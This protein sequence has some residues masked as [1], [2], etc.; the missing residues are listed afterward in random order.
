M[1]QVPEQSDSPAPDLANIDKATYDEMRRI[2][3]RLV[4]RGRNPTLNATAL[5]H[6]VWIKMQ[7]ASNL[8]IASRA[9]FV[10]TVIKVARELTTDSIRKRLARKRNGGAVVPLYLDGLPA[11]QVSAETILQISQAL[12]A[13]EQKDERMARIFEA[14]Y[15]VGMSAAEISEEFEIPLRTAERSLAYSRAWFETRLRA[16]PPEAKGES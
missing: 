11:R 16:K 4:R 5:L 9:H 6:E 3:G 13:L 2:A 7:K 1:A 14:R 10:A 8:R 12:T 15:F